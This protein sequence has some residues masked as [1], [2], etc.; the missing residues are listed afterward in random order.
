MICVYKALTNSKK[1][2]DN[3]LFIQLIKNALKF[4]S[5]MTYQLTVDKKTFSGSIQYTNWPLFLPRLKIH[6]TK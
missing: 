4:S 6:R 2:I 3:S 5:K 1:T